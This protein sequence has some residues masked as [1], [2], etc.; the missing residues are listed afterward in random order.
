[1]SSHKIG[2][3]R[4]AGIVFALVGAA[5][6]WFGR[7]LPFGSLTN[8]GSGFIPRITWSGLLAIGLYKMAKSILRPDESVGRLFPRPLLLISLAFVLFGLLVERA[9]LA[10][11]IAAMLIPVEFAGTHKKSLRSLLILIVALTVFSLVVFR[12]VL[13]IPLEVLP[14]WS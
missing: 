2:A 13:G 10:I 3:E 11:A 9:G 8:I 7:D 12:Y 14:K 1:M 4:A 5:G 6:L